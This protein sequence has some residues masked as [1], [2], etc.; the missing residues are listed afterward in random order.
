MDVPTLQPT[1]AFSKAVCDDKCR[2]V[3]TYYNLL[4]FVDIV[5]VLERIT[6]YFDLKSL[7]QYPSISRCRL[8]HNHQW[9]VGI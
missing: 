5:L 6:H 2:N 1:Q 4:Y 9:T 8:S 7:K 3:I